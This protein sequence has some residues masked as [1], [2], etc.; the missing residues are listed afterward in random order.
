M[1]YDKEALFQR[2]RRVLEEDYSVWHISDLTILGAG[3]DTL[4]CRAD[5]QAFGPITFKVPWQ[6]WIT[7]RNDPKVDARALL[8]QEAALA[9]H[10]ATHGVLTP[11]VYAFHQGDDDFDFLVSELIEQDQSLPNEHDFG[12]LMRALHESPLLQ[13]SLAMNL[14]DLP[15]ES[16]LAQRLSERLKV[17]EQLSREQFATLP[18][19]KELEAML[20]WPGATRRILH[21]DA[22]PEN[23]LTRKGTILALIDWSNALFGD[24]ALDLA[25]T[26]EYGYLSEEF[27]AGY[28]NAHCFAH[29]PPLVELLYRLD[30]ATMLAVVFFSSAPNAQR[31]KIQVQRVAELCKLL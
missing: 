26:A 29:V 23:L 7:N 24:P 8:Y 3:L 18:N 11:E 30:T 13:I 15:L 17:L 20:S 16:L 25:R 1:K 2:L 6:R 9:T 22:R 10:L 21:M 14:E 4:V 31:G 28:G 5:S 19:A 12:T 27:L